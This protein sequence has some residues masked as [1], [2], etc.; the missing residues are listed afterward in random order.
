MKN[1]HTLESGQMW[2]QIWL[3]LLKAKESLTNDISPHTPLFIFVLLTL[4]LLYIIRKFLI[5]RSLL[6]QK[7]VF[8]E[9]TPPAFTD[10]T[11]Y[12]TQQLF[13]V[14][15]NA[16]TQKT[17]IDRLLGKKVLF[18]FEIVSTR[19]KGIRYLVRATQEQA[20]VI[21]RSVVA[22]LPQVR[23]KRV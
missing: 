8:L 10:K 4:V 19:E 3:Q 17:F 5:L 23:V 7:T 18:S 12:T 15:H 21:E 11:A 16:G 22:Y 14:L 6:R 1:I 2:N 20:Q 9:L 13:L